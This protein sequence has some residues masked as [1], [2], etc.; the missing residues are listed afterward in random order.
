MTEKQKIKLFQKSKIR[1]TW[2]HNN[3]EWLFSVV[4]VCAALAQ[5]ASKD[6]GAYWRKLKQRLK[7]EGSES[8]TKCHG[9]KMLAQDGKQRLTDVANTEVLLRI[10]QSIPSKKAEP[11]KQWLAQVGS[12]RINEINDPELAIERAMDMYLSKGYSREWILQRLQ[13]IKIRRKLT[14]EWDKHGIKK[15][16]EYAILTD[17]ISKGWSGMTTREYKD[18][19]GLHNE[20]LRDNMTDMELVFN[21]LAEATTTEMSKQEQ[22]ETFTENQQVAKKGGETAGEARRLVEKRLGKSVITSEDHFEQIKSELAQQHKIESHTEESDLA[23]ILA[24]IEEFG[25]ITISQ[26]ENSILGISRRSLQRRFKTL[27][28]KKIIR[29]EGETNRRR[30]VLV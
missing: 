5:S 16:L 22:P 3:E 11:F 2:D 10:I 20:S 23:I 19:K 13:S 12:E 6:P 14:D 1:T 24:H 25:A 18:Y 9:L 21:M 29:S 27:V 4:D 7:D 30:Y 28:D 17:E 26:A 15:G 8:V